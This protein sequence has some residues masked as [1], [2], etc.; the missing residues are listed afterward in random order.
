V[1]RSLCAAQ[2]IEEENKQLTTKTPTSPSIF[3]TTSGQN[4]NRTYVPHV[5]PGRRDDFSSRDR[6]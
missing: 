1:T 3:L 5:V 4:I 2:A 6:Y